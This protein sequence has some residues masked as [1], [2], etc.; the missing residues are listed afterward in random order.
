MG[1]SKA[2]KNLLATLTAGLTEP[3]NTSNSDVDITIP[4]VPQAAQGNATVTYNDP[5]PSFS[6][7]NGP[8]RPR[9]ESRGYEKPV[10]FR[11][12][13]SLLDDMQQWAKF[14]G[15]TF[16]QAVTEAIREYMAPRAEKLEKFRALLATE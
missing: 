4:P 12:P 6:V 5:V 2:T 11:L 3:E 10:T 9:N 8:G 14:N 15:S 16:T 13:V 7:H 1:K